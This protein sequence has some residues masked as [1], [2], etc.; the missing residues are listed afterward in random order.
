MFLKDIQQVASVE[1]NR[2]YNWDVRFVKC[3][4]APAPPAP[5]DSWFPAVSVDL[6]SY[7]ISSFTYSSPVMTHTIPQSCT[8]LNLPITFLDDHNLTLLRWVREWVEKD[9]LHM[10]EENP[11]LGYISEVVR[12]LHLVR[13]KWEKFQKKN[14]DYR[15]YWVYP[16]GS[17][18]ESL[19]SDSSTLQRTVT[20]Q[21]TGLADCKI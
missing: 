12:P 6:P 14:V 21:V 16:D 10:A 8:T 2:S 1:W 4:T 5:F 3:S 18:V 17:L 9:M 7:N 11:Y 20:F 13:Y 15:A 19:A